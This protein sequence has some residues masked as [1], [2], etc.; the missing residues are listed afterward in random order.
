MAGQRRDEVGLRRVTATMPM[1]SQLHPSRSP[2]TMARM[3]GADEV[4]TLITG[5]RLGPY[6]ILSAF[7]AGGMGELSFTT[8]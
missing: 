7:G 5:A 4:M 6:E 8:P 1:P 3:I 2:A